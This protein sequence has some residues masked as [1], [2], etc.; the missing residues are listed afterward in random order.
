MANNLGVTTGADATVKTLNTATTL[1]VPCHIGGSQD[2]ICR[3]TSIADA[4]GAQNDLNLLAAAVAAGT[5][6]VVTQIWVKADKNNTGN[7]AVTIGFGT[8]NTPAA[9]ATGTSGLIID[10]DLGPGE[11]HQIGNGAGIVAIGAS[12]EELRMDCE[13]PV[14]GRFTVGLT[15]LL[16]TPA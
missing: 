12:D 8:A 13:D 7:V 5:Q 1:H 10:E 4:D 6:A 15:Y 14:G 9:S 3:T 2:V 11:G 16:I